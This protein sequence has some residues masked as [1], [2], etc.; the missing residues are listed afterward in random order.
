MWRHAPR[1]IR[2]SDRADIV[3]V[4]G[5]ISGL[6]CA[7]RLAHSEKYRDRTVLVLEASDRLGGR[8]ET[9]Q[10]RGT[11]FNAEFG[12]MR[13]ERKVQPRFKALTDQLGIAFSPFG[14]PTAGDD[15]WPLYDVA[16][17]ENHLDSLQLLK[18]GLLRI[19]G[20]QKE[21]VSAVD[22]WIKSLTEKDF[23]KVRRTQPGTRD[24]VKLHQQG[25]WNA[26][27]DVLSHQ[28]I[29]KIRDQGTFY[30]LLPENPNA[31]EWAIWWLRNFKP[32]AADM[33]GIQGGSDQVVQRL[34]DSFKDTKVKTRC[35]REVTRIVRRRKGSGLVIEQRDGTRVTAASHLILALPQLPLTKL[36]TAFPDDVKE[37]LASVIAFPLLKVFFVVENPRWTPNTPAQ[38]RAGTLPT[39]EIHYYPTEGEEKDQGQDDQRKLGMVMLYTDRPSTQYWAHYVPGYLTGEPI[40]HATT[41]EEEEETCDERLVSRFAK[42]LAA[43]AE[44]HAHEVERGFADA[45]ARA[46]EVEDAVSERLSPAS[47][48][49]DNETVGDVAQTLH[50]SVANLLRRY[51]P[52]WAFERLVVTGGVR[53]D[54]TFQHLE[55]RV[56]PEVFN[57]E[58]Q[59]I[60]EDEVK[61]K[62][63]HAVI[64]CG[65]R[66]WGREPFG[67]AC[68]VW[69]PGSRS[70]DLMGRLQAFSLDGSKRSKRNLHVCG[71]AYSDYQGFIEGAL[72]SADRA[73]A[74]MGLPPFVAGDDCE[75]FPGHEN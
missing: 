32:S 6:Y 41:Y 45:K 26:L 9:W 42:Y 28:S 21:S 2:P 27:S 44:A 7:W 56:V 33:E 72:R 31:A 47:T 50:T 55:S 68:H 51:L 62:Y 22:N 63:E 71:E 53:D 29:L 25:F 4:G 57:E 3:I 35:S 10:P 11:G 64:A 66:D 23:C 75:H 5:G 20:K 13:F 67:G 59:R 19:F 46:H 36:S 49:E 58:D 30:H 60:T 40:Y 34:L 52:P 65:I 1:R 73:L 8:I 70:E 37:A 74:T 14:G 16:V 24:K 15:D 12:P 48:R 61:E 69:K 43:D 17:D 39:R 54:E 38:T 18:L